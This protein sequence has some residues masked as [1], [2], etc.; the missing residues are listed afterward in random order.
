M[1]LNG[2]RSVYDTD[3]F[4]PVMERAAELVGIRYGADAKTDF[5][6]RVIGDHSRAVTFLVGDGVLPSNEGRGY[7]LRRVLRRA[8][9][10]GHF[11]GL[12]EPFL[13]IDRRRGD[14]PHGR[15]LPGAGH[16]AAISSCASS[17][18][19]SAA[20]ARP[21][22]RAWSGWTRCWT[23]CR[24]RPCP[25]QDAFRLYDTFGFPLDITKD[26]ASERGFTVDEDG[27]RTAMEEQ[28]ERARKA[29][30]FGLD[31]WQET[32][33]SLALA[34]TP[35]LGYGALAAPAT[36]L[37]I[38]RDGVVG[39]RG[40]GR[41]GRGDRPEPDA[42]LRRVGRP[43]RRHRCARRVPTAAWSGDRHAK[44]PWAASIVHLGTVESGSLRVG[45][46][47]QRAGRPGAPAGHRP[48]PHGHP[49]PSQGAARRPGRTRHPARLPRGAR[50]SAL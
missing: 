37:N 29:K 15:G 39:D 45:Q 43:G 21:S 42:L 28:R 35:F 31:A 32:Y 50:P 25:A 20:S 10:H 30:K 18:R 4:M 12:G 16:A 7:I 38:M 8:V 23:A 9:R 48:Q 17:T 19:R 6:L 27:F 14:R 1:V 46:S 3:L 49:P 34:E 22:A 44:R 13:A 11:L 26:R 2:Y 40:P 33:R 24:A 41:R 5:S 36:V 47:V